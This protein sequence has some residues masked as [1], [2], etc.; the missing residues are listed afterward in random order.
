MKHFSKFETA[1]L[2]TSL[3]SSSHDVNEPFRIKLKIIQNYMSKN[4]AHTAVHLKNFK[5]TSC[6]GFCYGFQ[7]TKT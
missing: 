2:V 1:L 7:Y 5:I 6:N 4:A 3:N